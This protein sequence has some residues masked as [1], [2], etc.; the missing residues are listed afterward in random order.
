LAFA[1]NTASCT[2]VQVVQIYGFFVNAP[3]SLS[4]VSGNGTISTPN[5]VITGQSIIGAN[6]E[7]YNVSVYCVSVGT[8]PVTITVTDSTG[9]VWTATGT[10]TVN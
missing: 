2:S 5:V 4:I 9:A 8:A 3:P 10:V 6:N 7:I 1:A